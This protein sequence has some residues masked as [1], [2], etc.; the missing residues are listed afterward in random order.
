MRYK[1]VVR[2]KVVSVYAVRVVQQPKTGRFAAP[3]P[4]EHRTA[5]PRPDAYMSVPRLG[6][7]HAPIWTRG[8]VA[9]GYGGFTYDIVP[10]YGVTRFAY[11]QPFG[12]PGT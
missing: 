11:S 6:I 3:P 8:Y 12:R 4:Q 5:L 9:D 2:R 1:T 7:S 10:Y